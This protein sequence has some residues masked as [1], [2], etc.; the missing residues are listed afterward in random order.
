MG[1]SKSLDR[2]AQAAIEALGE[3][4]GREGCDACEKHLELIKRWGPLEE[5][6]ALR[7]FLGTFNWIRGHFP[8]E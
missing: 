8:K 6:G 3:I 5:I 1:A 2:L 7:R 4:V